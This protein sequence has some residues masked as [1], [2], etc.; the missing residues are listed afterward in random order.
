[1]FKLSKLFGTKLSSLDFETG[2]KAV[3]KPVEFVEVEGLPKIDQAFLD[4]FEARKPWNT[5]RYKFFNFFRQWGMT[6]F[7]VIA[8]LPCILFL[9]EPR[10]FGG[11]FYTWIALACVF[12]AI[13]MDCYFVPGA[14][15]QKLTI[16]EIYE[17]LYSEDFKKI[18]TQ[19]DREFSQYKKNFLK[20][21][22]GLPVLMVV[23]GWVSIVIGLHPVAMHFIALGCAVFT[24]W[25][26]LYKWPYDFSDE[27]FRRDRWWPDFSELLKFGHIFGNHFFSVFCIPFFIGPIIYLLHLAGFT[28]ILLILNIGEPRTA[29]ALEFVTKPVMTY[30][31]LLIPSFY[32][33][34]STTMTV[35]IKFVS[36]ASEILKL[37]EE[38]DRNL[39]EIQ[40]K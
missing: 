39:T 10:I 40:S 30:I 1:M 35:G 15:D 19:H 3:P 34:L 31:M 36:F 14:P 33:F 22:L 6:V 27:F 8:F 18:E 26:F 16:Y 13:L 12:L 20:Q 32:L 11:M 28:W 25:W 38:Q 2:K 17:Y 37:K 7:V 21:L 4:D 24:A 29:A 23:F 9:E 5:A